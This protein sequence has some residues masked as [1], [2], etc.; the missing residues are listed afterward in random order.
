MSPLISTWLIDWTSPSTIVTTSSPWGGIMLMILFVS[1]NSICSLKFI[2]SMC[3][4]YVVSRSLSL[5]RIVSSSFLVSLVGS[6][7]SIIA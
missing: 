2:E 5:L 1:K 7:R 4:P 3:F 6:G